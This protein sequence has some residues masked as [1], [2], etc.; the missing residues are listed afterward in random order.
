MKQL[1]LT[2]VEMAHIHWVRYLLNEGD[3]DRT[4]S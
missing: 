1:A 3:R 2:A 4:F